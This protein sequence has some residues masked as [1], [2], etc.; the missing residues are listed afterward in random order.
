M[1]AAPGKQSAT[2][3]LRMHALMLGDRINSS[4]LEI[5]TLIS[6]T[7]V[8]FR[9]HAGL[10]VIFRYGVVVLIGL[11]PSEEK[12]LI[13]SLKARVTGELSPY[14]EEIAQAQLCKDE[15]AEAIQPG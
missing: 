14:E 3:T 5:G 4:G 2:P 9:V 13:D 10:A 6:S 1:T 15:S 12:V 11:L 7:P 8:A